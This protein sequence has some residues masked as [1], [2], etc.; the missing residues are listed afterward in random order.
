MAKL[1]NNV[2]APIKD[3]K[4]NEETALQLGLREL[5]I[6]SP[7]DIVNVFESEGVDEEVTAHFRSPLELKGLAKNDLRHDEKTEKLAETIFNVFAIAPEI[8]PKLDDNKK[9]IKGQFIE[10]TNA[11]RLMT[12]IDTQKFAY[13]LQARKGGAKV[14]L[15]TAVSIADIRNVVATAVNSL[16]E[17]DV[18]KDSN[19]IAFSNGADKTKQVGKFTKIT[20]KEKDLEFSLELVQKIK[21]VPCADTTEAPKEVDTAKKDE[22]TQEVVTN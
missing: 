4:P 1:N 3:D 15:H 20:G 21:E 7:A 5:V 6:T 2:T 11:D 14:D 19:G 8:L 18:R 17:K 13:R 16:N 9:V 22:K 12:A 10:Q